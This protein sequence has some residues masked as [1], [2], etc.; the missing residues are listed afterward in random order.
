MDDVLSVTWPAKHRATIEWLCRIS[1]VSRANEVADRAERLALFRLRG[2][3]GLRVIISQGDIE[4]AVS[5][6]GDEFLPGLEGG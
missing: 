5:V 2:R 4:G 3:D 6:A 1:G